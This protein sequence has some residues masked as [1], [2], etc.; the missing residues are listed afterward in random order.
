MT[1]GLPGFGAAHRIVEEDEVFIPRDVNQDEQIVL[2]GEIEKPARRDVIDAE[3][4][5]AEFLDEREIGSGLFEGSEG[6]SV[7]S[8]S[9]WAIGDAL[10]IKF[11]SAATKKFSVHGDARTLGE[12][13]CHGGQTLAGS[14]LITLI[15]IT[16]AA[17]RGKPG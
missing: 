6:L 17:L 2:R 11:L 12:Q 7:F 3:K 1:D 5:C 15:P 13:I 14:D 4:I 9:K 16:N 8:G 10:E